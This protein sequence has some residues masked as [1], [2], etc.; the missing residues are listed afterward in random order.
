MKKNFTAQNIKHL[1]KKK[2]LSQDLLAKN[3]GITRQTLGNYENGE[4]DPPFNIAANFARLFNIS[5]EELCW[6]D[7]ESG[8]FAISDTAPQ[9]K[10]ALVESGEKDWNVSMLDVKASAGYLANMNDITYLD[11]LEKY[12][13]PFLDKWGDY[14]GF[15]IEGDSMLPIASGSIIVCERIPLSSF[16]TL[17]PGALCV[18]VTIEGVVFKQ[19][20]ILQDKGAVQLISFN[21]MYDPYEIRVNDIREAWRYKM[22]LSKE[23]PS[24]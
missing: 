1:R 5:L 10:P 22:F 20:N 4:T 18:L 13:F 23:I 21:R 3:L 14:R 8:R 2:N 24:M 11:K 19:I 16:Y 12:N 17:K 6:K 7:I 9:A 15:M